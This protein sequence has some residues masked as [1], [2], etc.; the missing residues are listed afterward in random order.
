M[1]KL[2]LGYGNKA[3]DAT[4]SG[5]SYEAT[6]PLTNLQDRMIGL[7]ARTADLTLASTQFDADIGD[8]PT[9]R[10]LA[11][12]NHNMSLDALY[13]IQGCSEATFADPEY[14]SGWA[15]V[16]PAVYHTAD[17]PWEAPNW[18]SGK[19]TE[20]ERAGYVWTLI[21][22]IGSTK[23][24]RYWRFEFDDQGNDA[25]YLQY[26]RLFVGQGWEPTYGVSA[27]AELGWEPNTDFQ[28][29]RSGAKVFDRRTPARVFTFNT[30]GLDEDEAMQ[31][32]FE[33][34]RVAGIDKE[35]VLI[36]D[37]ED[38]IHALRRRYLGTLQRLSPIRF[39]A[40]T[41]GV[42]GWSVEEVL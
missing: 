35:V 9:T 20:E 37:D 39:P 3:D 36:F 5:G 23:R 42:T 14:D 16:W 2:V 4:L 10:V 32:A 24:L 28:R 11:L 33:L 15:E 22:D 1:G 18:W 40:L 8:R 12:A 17:L 7:V 30:E 21:H 27:E 34:Q 6:L 13:R 19:Y 26:G 38:T 25:G 29:T 31:F 41:A